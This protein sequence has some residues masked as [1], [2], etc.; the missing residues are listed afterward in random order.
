MKLSHVYLFSEKLIKKFYSVTFLGIISVAWWRLLQLAHSVKRI[1]ERV[2]P[3]QPLSKSSVSACRILVSLCL[4]S[5]LHAMRQLYCPPL[6]EDHSLLLRRGHHCE[7]NHNPIIPVKDGQHSF[8]RPVNG[9]VPR[10]V[11]RSSEVLPG[12][13]LSGREDRHGEKVLGQ[14]PSRVSAFGTPC[15]VFPTGRGCRAAC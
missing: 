12:T 4:F 3:T 6:P 15:H 8:T 13:F 9:A 1:A 11:C 5:T 14:Q 2:T 7:R 10:L